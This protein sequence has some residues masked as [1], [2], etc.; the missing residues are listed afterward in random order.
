MWIIMI[1]CSKDWNIAK[2]EGHNCQFTTMA[3]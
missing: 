1:G 3:T 2:Y